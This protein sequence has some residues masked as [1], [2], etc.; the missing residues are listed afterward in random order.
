MG[1]LEPVEYEQSKHISHEKPLPER[2]KVLDLGKDA[3]QE[4]DKKGIIG[5]FDICYLEGN[6]K[7]TGMCYQTF[8]NSEAVR[9]IELYLKEREN[10]NKD[11]WLF[12]NI[13]ANKNG[14][15]TK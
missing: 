14:K 15:Y 6:R 3:F 8:F 10:L 7:K 9:M 5:E 11:S 4:G 1:F 2:S 12:V 13:K